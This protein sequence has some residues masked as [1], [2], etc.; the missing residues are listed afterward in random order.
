VGLRASHP[1]LDVDLIEC[2]LALPPELAF[3]ARLSR[4]LL[5][6]S[7]CGLIPEPVRLRPSKSSFDALFHE[8]LAGGELAVARSLVLADDAEVG[9]FV[10]VERV[11]A[12]LFAAPPPRTGGALQS[13]ALQVW[14]LVTAESWLRHQAGRPLQAPTAGVQT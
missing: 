14:R 4:P 12:Q 8:S 11:R 13:W 6:E 2:V 9:A 1:L 5:R 7:V 10:D 3:D